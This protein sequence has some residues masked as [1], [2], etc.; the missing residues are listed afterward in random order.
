MNNLT[1]SL[2][3]IFYYF[4]T[5][6]LQ[7]DCS[8]ILYSTTDACSQRSNEELSVTK[9]LNETDDE[10]LHNLQERLFPSDV[11]EEILRKPL[12]IRNSGRFFKINQI[13]MFF[14][15]KY[16]SYYFSF[17][18]LLDD[19]PKL[20]DVHQTLSSRG[21]TIKHRFDNETYGLSMYFLFKKLLNFESR[22]SLFLEDENK[23]ALNFTIL[24]NF[25]R[26]SDA[27][28][29]IEEHLTIPQNYVDL[30]KYFRIYIQIN[31]NQL[32]KFCM[33][34][35]TDKRNCF[36]IYGSFPSV[37]IVIPIEMAGNIDLFS[38]STLID[39][40]EHE[41]NICK[42]SIGFTKGPDILENHNFQHSLGK[43]GTILLMV[44]FKKIAPH[45]T[46]FTHCGK[47][48]NSRILKLRVHS[49]KI[50]WEEFREWVSIN[51]NNFVGCFLHYF[52]SYSLKN[53]FIHIEP[54]SY[55]QYQMNKMGMVCEEK[56]PYWSG[57]KLMVVITFMLGGFGLG[58]VTT[59]SSL[60][61]VV[62]YISFICELK[63][64]DQNYIIDYSSWLYV[65]DDLIYFYLNMSV[66]CSYP[67][68]N[69][70]SSIV[71]TFLNEANPFV[72]LKIDSN[73][74]EE[75]NRTCKR[76][77][78]H[79]NKTSTK[80]TISYKM[81]NQI[82]SE[83]IDS[84]TPTNLTD[85]RKFIESK[86][87][88]ATKQPTLYNITQF[89]TLIT[90]ENWTY[91]HSFHNLLHDYKKPDVSITNH[92]VEN[93][94]FQIFSAVGQLI[95]TVNVQDGNNI[96]N[97]QYLTTLNFS[98]QTPVETMDL[99][100]VN[101]C[102]EEKVLLKYTF[103]PTF[104]V[105]VYEKDFIRRILI[106]KIFLQKIKY[107]K[108]YINME[109]NILT[110]VCITIQFVK[111]LCFEI[112]D[113][114]KSIGIIIP[115]ILFSKKIPK[116]N[117]VIIDYTEEPDNSCLWNLCIFKNNRLY[118]M[119]N[120]RNKLGKVGTISFF[121]PNK[122]YANIGILTSCKERQDKRILKI[123]VL[124]R[125]IGW[126]N[127]NNWT[128]LTPKKRIGCLILSYNTDNHHFVH[129]KPS[130]HIIVK[131]NS[132]G[133]LNFTCPVDNTL[134]RFFNLSRILVLGT[135]MAYIHVSL[136][137]QCKFNLQN[138]MPF[139]LFFDKYPA[140]GININ[141]EETIIGRKAYRL[142]ASRF[143]CA[144]IEHNFTIDV[145]DEW[146]TELNETV[147]PNDLLEMITTKPFYLINVYKEIKVTH[148]Q[149]TIVTSNYTIYN[150]FQALL[151]D[152]NKPDDAAL[153]LSSEC[154]TIDRVVSL[155]PQEHQTT[156]MIWIKQ[157]NRIYYLD[158]WTQKKTFYTADMIFIFKNH[159]TFRD[160][161]KLFLYNE[162][163]PVLRYTFLPS[164]HNSYNISKSLYVKINI[165]YEFIEE[166]E[167][168]FATYFKFIANTLD[169]PLREFCIE[170]RC[171]GI[172]GSLGSTAI[173]I[174]LRRK[175][176]LEKNDANWGVRYPKSYDLLGGST[177]FDYVENDENACKWSVAFSKQGEIVE[178]HHFQDMLNLS[179]VGTLI[180]VLNFTTGHEL[181]VITRCD[182]LQKGRIIKV[183]VLSGMERYER[184]D[185]WVS[186]TP[187]M[188]LGCL[189][190][191]YKWRRIKF[192][193]LTYPPDR[194]EKGDL[195]LL[196]WSCPE[197]QKLLPIEIPRSFVVVTYMVYSFIIGFII[198]L[199][200]IYCLIKIFE[201]RRDPFHTTK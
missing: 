118:S 47:Y 34:A 164:F 26:R 49:N 197:Y 195:E 58:F 169:N 102:D 182:T 83:W 140:N 39:Y 1:F 110:Q 8:D 137:V 116:Y 199:I 180:F 109:K 181:S 121:V 171:F 148:V 40:I 5:P 120:F 14:T 188:H 186:I 167:Y 131:V 162:S 119:H 33:R 22:I 198:T 67:P 185:E 170:N 194:F 144:W 166:S 75:I 15:Y 52:V 193:V 145:G 55:Q 6:Q 3:L 88:F 153:V 189:I 156:P 187:K 68:A 139:L 123:R 60:I 154:R 157:Y 200:S 177:I 19:Y 178:L 150:T 100:E 12:F 138:R 18:K 142:N 74:I 23:F 94:V 108:I 24:P 84:L 107:F 21:N 38:R 134:I 176:L 141:L 29:E 112:Y 97:K 45:I 36:Y 91:Y 48:Q 32:I 30:S 53:T 163:Y 96:F 65:C 104:D 125:L 161:L 56:Q 127:L 160:E 63:E 46:F 135:W 183:R 201:S 27:S 196:G 9:F 89:T 13:H 133:I 106:P 44:D 17:H 130:K 93:S 16:T 76:K 114:H 143:M 103:L 111:S 113:I 172:F 155:Q 7:V 132:L 122:Y 98:F 2:S 87:L 51:P 95:E 20:N 41:D 179:K 37:G 73:A 35:K 175:L 101:L 62:S 72:E 78:K 59:L 129:D 152:F 25:D 174:S 105:M 149:F 86:P 168:R 124:S 90:F 158:G 151:V 10:W 173:I 192:S 128:S 4:H 61:S 64:D 85:F 54:T 11:N 77:K 115:K 80:P 190:N 159:I 165:P 69:S 191:R 70:Y 184:F 57:G 79:F 126:E 81:T 117:D 50:G 28:T 99:L 147:H 92:S 82:I 136:E 42:W 146:L 66:Y 71:L 31:D 43:N